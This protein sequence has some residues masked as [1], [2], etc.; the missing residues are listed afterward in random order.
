MVSAME[1]RAAEDGFCLERV[2]E[3]G[4]GVFEFVDCAVGC[5]VETPCAAQ[6][7]DADFVGEPLGHPLAGCLVGECEEDEVDLILRDEIPGECVDR[8]LGAA[9]AEGEMGGAGL[10]G[11]WCRRRRLRGRGRAAACPA[12]AGGRGAG[13]QARRRSSRRLR[14][15]RCGGGFG[16]SGTGN[17]K[18]C[19]AGRAHCAW[20]GSL[21]DLCWWSRRCL[22]SRGL[23]LV[24][25]ES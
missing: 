1:F 25:M 22:A 5:F 8:G 7:D 2:G 11:G 14:R 21:R 15:G 13:G 3:G 4:I 9:L 6:V 23:P 17:L 18:D 20:G 10:R 24:G 12:G 19:P 16:C